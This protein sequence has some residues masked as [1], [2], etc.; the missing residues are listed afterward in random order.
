VSHHPDGDAHGP[1]WF[2]TKSSM[3]PAKRTGPRNVLAFQMVISACCTAW[4]YRGGRCRCSRFVAPPTRM[5]S[6]RRYR[7]PACCRTPA[8]CLLQYP[9]DSQKSS[10]TAVVAV[11]PAV[12]HAHPVTVVGFYVP[13]SQDPF[14]L[15]LSR[16]KDQ[17]YSVILHVLLLMSRRS[18]FTS[19]LDES[20]RGTS[21]FRKL[22][23]LL[24]LSINS[25]IFPSFIPNTS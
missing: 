13:T 14:R 21:L 7:C 4:P 8:A 10:S 3:P 24:R 1:F 6:P 22:P 15:L 12:R 25:R 2:S 9:V 11:L 17:Q 16:P 18:Q 19:T 23:I 5:H 20:M